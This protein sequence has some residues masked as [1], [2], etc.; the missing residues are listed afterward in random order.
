MDESK[1]PDTP[2]KV[3]AFFAEVAFVDCPDCGDTNEIG[4]GGVCVWRRSELEISL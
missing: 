4:E 2:K 1:A 3:T